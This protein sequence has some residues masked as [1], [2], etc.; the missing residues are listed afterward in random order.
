M[1]ILFLGDIMGR[2]GRRVVSTLLSQL[3]KDQKID[4]I[5]ANCENLAGGKGINPEKIIEM[6][7]ASIDFFTSGNHIWSNRKIYSYLDDPKFPVLRPANYPPVAEMH[8]RGAE[9]VF[10]KDKKKLLIINLIGRVFMSKHYDCPFRVADAI[11]EKYKDHDFEAIF[12]DFH[13]EATSEKIALKHYLD[14]RITALIGTHTHVPTADEQITQNGTAY[15]TDV[16]MCGPLD[17]V[18][19]MKKDNVIQS[20]LTQIPWKFEVETGQSELNGVII[21]CKNSKASH[22]ERINLVETS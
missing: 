19:G 12:V 9:I 5:I 22:V 1:K 10:T 6:Q 15:L 14:G 13:A 4:F 8:G 17:S 20:F 11:L 21:E 3:K 18:L 16:G 7:K 2:G